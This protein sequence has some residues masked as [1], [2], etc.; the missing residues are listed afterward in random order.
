MKTENTNRTSPLLK[1][2]KALT[3]ILLITF[4][5]KASA[6]CTANFTY[7]VDTTNNGVV[8]FTNT[9]SS[10]GSVQYAWDF[11]DGQSAYS[12]SPT[13]TYSF[14]GTDTVTLM[15]Y[16]SLALGGGCSDTVSYVLSVIHIT[17]PACFAHYTAVDSLGYIYFVNASSGGT[18]TSYFWDFGDGDTLTTYGNAV[19]SYGPGMYTACLTVNNPSISCSVTYCDSVMVNSCGAYFTSTAD[20]SGFGETF[21]SSVTG[22]GDTYYWDFGDGNTSTLANPYHVYAASGT[23]YVQLGVTSSTDPGCGATH[24]NYV[25]VSNHCS[26]AFTIA[27]DSLD[28]YHF[29]IYNNATSPGSGITY[30]WDF[31]DG[32]TSTAAYPN[33]TYAGTGPYYL[34]LTITSTDTVCTATHCDSLIA[35]RSTSTISVTVLAPLTT[36]VNEASEAASI[37]E[38]YPNPFNGSTTINYS[39][40]KNAAV[41]LTVMDLLGNKIALLESSQKS[42]GSYSTVWNADGIAPGLYL[43][44]MKTNNRITTKKIVISK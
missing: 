40:S 25:N 3:V 10:A 20:A 30:L 39:I 11:G 33:H 5:F 32:A 23:Y 8:S 9:S 21:T 28:L 37:L 27:Q 1:L 15:M 35:G 31:G 17:P 18:G 4:G 34:C 36:G 29:N 22:S 41:E 2:T 14:T 16:D 43:L 24:N 6:Q 38:N 12:A 42:A 44:Q 13:H 19:H 7:V 26:A